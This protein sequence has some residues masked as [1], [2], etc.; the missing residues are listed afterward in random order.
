MYVMECRLGNDGWHKSRLRNPKVFLLL[1]KEKQEV[2]ELWNK[3]SESH[4]IKLKTE[5]QIE[6]NIEKNSYTG[7]FIKN[8]PYSNWKNWYIIWKFNLKHHNK[9]FFYSVLLRIVKN[10]FNPLL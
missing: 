8:C 9:I 2:A 3:W 10:Y 5:A 1:D 6:L 4:E 7:C